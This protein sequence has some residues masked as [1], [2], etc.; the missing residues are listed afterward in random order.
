MQPAGSFADNAHIYIRV[1]ASR[2]AQKAILTHAFRSCAWQGL[3][4]IPEDRAQHREMLCRW[5]P[6]FSRVLMCHVRRHGDPVREL[7]GVLLPHELQEVL[8]AQHRPNY[9]L[10]VGVIQPGWA[11]PSVGCTPLFGSIG[12][13]AA[14]FVAAELAA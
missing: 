12:Q 9:V 4:W 13:A 8:L 3:A 6:A 1:F 7:Q 5:V 14:S 10:Q 11:G 2:G